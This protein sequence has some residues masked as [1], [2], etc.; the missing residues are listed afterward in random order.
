MPT[1]KSRVDRKKRK[2]T[3]SR[4]EKQLAQTNSALMA[5]TGVLL[6]LGASALLGNSKSKGKKNT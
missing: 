2:S 1:R 5:P 3:L 6:I 4:Q